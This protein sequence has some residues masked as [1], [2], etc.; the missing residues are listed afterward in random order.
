M[1]EDPQPYLEGVC[2][3]LARQGILA[4]PAAR[5]GFAGQEI[6]R[7]AREIG[8]GLIGMATEGKSGFPRLLAG[9][10]AEEVL[11]SAPCPVLLRRWAPV[12]AGAPRASALP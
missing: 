6:V 11:R 8:A 9:S 7:L 5:E 2:G 4:V 1:R 12:E 10:V 3:R